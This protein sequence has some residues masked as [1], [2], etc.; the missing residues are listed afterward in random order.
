MQE[1]V[2]V[3]DLRGGGGGDG[4]DN[5]AGGGGTLPTTGSDG[6]VLTYTLYGGLGAILLGAGAIWLTRTRRRITE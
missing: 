1:N 4:D 3:V 5:N 6:S 2:T